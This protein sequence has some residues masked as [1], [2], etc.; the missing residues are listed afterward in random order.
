MTYFIE[1]LPN[2]RWGIYVEWRL[3]ATIGCHQTA[4]KIL[5]LL[6][7]AKEVK[8]RHQYISGLNYKRGSKNQAA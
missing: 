3:L 6:Q 5:A 8:A 2:G 7:T 4:L 1:Q